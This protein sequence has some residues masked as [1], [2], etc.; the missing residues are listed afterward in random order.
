L[1]AALR[2]QLN[3]LSL[4]P[5][6]FDDIEDCANADISLSR[7]PTEAKWSRFFKE[8]LNIVSRS[9]R[10]YEKIVEAA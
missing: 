2:E 1:Q 6:F 5:D 3:E 9:C 8:L 4:D 7:V 10:T